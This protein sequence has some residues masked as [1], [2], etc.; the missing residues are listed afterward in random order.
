M[1][2]HNPQLTYFLDEV[3]KDKPF[4]EEKQVFP[5]FLYNRKIDL[6]ILLGLL[7]RGNQADILKQDQNQ[8]EEI[9][10]IKE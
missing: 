7:L 9:Q 4:K 2:L 1:Y 6:A 8:E 3:R 10:E 5:T